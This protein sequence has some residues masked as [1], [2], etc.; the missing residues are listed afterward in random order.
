[1][2]EVSCKKPYRF[3]ETEEELKPFT[4]SGTSL[5]NSE[6]TKPLFKCAAIDYGAKTS[7]SAA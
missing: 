5:Y 7:I 3:S 1:M 6:R 2:R 4:V